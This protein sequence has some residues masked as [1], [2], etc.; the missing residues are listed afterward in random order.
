[1]L[2]V[3]GVVTDTMSY[4]L[5]DLIYGLLR[6]AWRWITAAGNPRDRSLRAATLAVVVIG[7]LVSATLLTMLESMDAYTLRF[8]SRIKQ[9]A[10]L[11]ADDRQALTA[12]VTAFRRFHDLPQEGDDQ[13]ISS[14]FSTPAALAGVEGDHFSADSRANESLAGEN[15]PLVAGAGVVSRDSGEARE[16]DAFVADF[17]RQHEISAELFEVFQEEANDHVDRIHAAL[18]QLEK[19]HGD[20]ELVQEIRRSAHTLKGAAGAVGL[21]G[22][23]Q[24]S[25]RMEDL[26]DAIHAGAVPLNS[27]LLNLLTT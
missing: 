10:R 15:A 22:V 17:F 9:G 18:R 12:A 7:G 21:L 25:H 4:L 8:E 16:R 19:N 23:T 2:K 24:L 26:L 20:R 11:I 13:A 14:L 6:R 3:A 27:E 1:M 5:L